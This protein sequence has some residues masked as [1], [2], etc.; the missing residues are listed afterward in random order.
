MV[1]CPQCQAPLAYEGATCGA[2]EARRMLVPGESPAKTSVAEVIEEAAKSIPEVHWTNGGLEVLPAP[3]PPPP[4]DVSSAS[5]TPAIETVT[6]PRPGLHLGRVLL[7]AVAIG[8]VVFGGIYACQVLPALRAASYALRAARAG[9]EELY[10]RSTSVLASTR[11][12]RSQLSGQGIAAEVET[13]PGYL[14]R[15][16]YRTSQT[17]SATA[18][19]F[20][21]LDTLAPLVRD[22]PDTA[23][24]VSFYAGDKHL[25]H[26]AYNPRTKQI[27][28]TPAA[29]EAPPAGEKAPKAAEIPGA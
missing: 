5:A 8:L 24:T 3:S 19:E 7:A 4:A 1:R 29:P 17:T 6:A 27:R 26:T 18:A 16:T 23:W 9:D 21:C 22:W 2:C 14:Y 11:S 10:Q 15:I 12:V 20:A 28:T 13:T 25:C